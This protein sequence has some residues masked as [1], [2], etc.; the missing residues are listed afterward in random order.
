MKKLDEEQQDKRRLQERVEKD[1]KTKRL[2]GLGGRLKLKEC[3]KISE[4]V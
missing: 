3:Q 1:H 2:G 4:R